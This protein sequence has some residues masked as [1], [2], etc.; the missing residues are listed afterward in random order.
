MDPFWWIHYLE[1]QAELCDSLRGL[2]PKISFG[3][4][5]LQGIKAR[6][7]VPFGVEI[8]GRFLAWISLLSFQT[9][10][11]ERWNSELEVPWYKVQCPDGRQ[12]KKTLRNDGNACLVNLESSYLWAV[13]RGDKIYWPQTIKQF[14]VVLL[15]SWNGICHAGHISRFARRFWDKMKYLF[16]IVSEMDQENKILFE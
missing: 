14:G 2:Q 12:W 4:S 13:F 8:S 9:K 1:A 3:I 10:V 5:D 6:Q 16:L 11:G 15:L 7:S